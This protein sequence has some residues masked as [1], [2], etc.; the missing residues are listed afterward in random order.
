MKY[1]SSVWSQI[2]QLDKNCYCIR[3]QRFFK[4]QNALAWPTK[5]DFGVFLISNVFQG[6]VLPQPFWE[7]PNHRLRTQR[8]IW[9]GLEVW[10]F[11]LLVHRKHSIKLSTWQDNLTSQTAFHNNGWH[12]SDHFQQSLYH[13]DTCTASFLPLCPYFIHAPI[14]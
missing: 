11:H 14:E 3:V 13:L 2:V 1:K 5:I 9:P 4:G 10:H 6:N 12:V 7:S 8:W